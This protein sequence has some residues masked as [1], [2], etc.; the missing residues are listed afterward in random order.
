VANVADGDMIDTL[1]VVD[2]NVK[3]EN[4][5]D[6]GYGRLSTYDTK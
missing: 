5:L 3:D 2:D 4:F 1:S 6:F